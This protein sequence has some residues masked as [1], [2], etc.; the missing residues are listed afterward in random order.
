MAINY[1]N[2]MITSQPLRKPE[3]N[4]QNQ[5]HKSQIQ[6][7]V[8][9]TTRFILL[10]KFKVPNT[11]NSTKIQSNSSTKY[12]NYAGL[13][14]SI[15]LANDTAFPMSR[16]SA[17]WSRDDAVHPHSRNNKDANFHLAIS[18]IIKNTAFTMSRSSAEWGMEDT[19]YLHSSIVHYI[20]LLYTSPSPRD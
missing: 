15:S 14:F 18:L 10:S 2:N 6:S 3:D 7:Q 19:A 17:E 9:I 13:N 11:R 12:I 20:C 16:S 1:R 4:I 8:P 5:Y